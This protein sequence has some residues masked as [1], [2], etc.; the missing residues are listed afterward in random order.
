MVTIMNTTDTYQQKRDQI[1]KDYQALLA[2]GQAV[3]LKKPASNVF[4]IRKSSAPRLDVRPLNQVIKVNV[5]ERTAEVEGMATYRT[6][7]D[8]TLKHG[9]LPTV[10]PEL[11]TITAGGAVSGCGLEASSFRYGMVHETVLSMEILLPSGDVVTVTPTNKYK[12]L[13]YGFPNSYGTLGYIL[14]LTIQLVPAK[15]YVHLEYHKLDNI[16]DVLAGIDQVVGTNKYKGKP[17]DFVEA[18]G[19][20]TNRLYLMTSR[21]VDK[22]PKKPSDYTYMK[23]FYRSIPEKGEDYLTAHDFIWRWD[24]DWYW[25]SKGFLMHW[26]TLRFLTGKWLLGSKGYWRLVRL[27]QKYKI[28]RK[29]RLLGGKPPIEVVVQDVQ[30]PL[31][32]SAEFWDFFTKKVPIRPIW[33]C[34][35]HSPGSDKFPLAK[36][37]AGRTYINFGFWEHIPRHGDELH[38]YN[39]LVEKEVVKLEGMKG[40]Y[41]EVFYN[42]KQFWQMFGGKAYTKLKAKYDPSGRLKDLYEKCVVERGH[43]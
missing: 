13:F 4:R 7:V 15:P 41:A 33:L 38:Y 21:F 5:K 3:R 28:E 17:V 37:D 6:I 20:D 39:K 10:V 25:C 30:I 12:D 31:D 40:L 2:A 29:L 19:F 1:V 9:L 42:K 36:M 27:N 11:A 24:T 43:Y 35:T 26:P 22:A 34:P 14:K 16:D 8:A 23:Q 18:V 32:K